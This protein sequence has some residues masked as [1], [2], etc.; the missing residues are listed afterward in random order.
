M[1]YT[2]YHCSNLINNIPN[3]DTS[4]VTNMVC[5]FRD[6]QNLVEVPNFNTNNVIYM[7][8]MFHGCYNLITVPSF[9]ISNVTMMGN[10]FVNCNH[11]SQPS[12]NNIVSMCVHAINVTNK[13]WD[14]ILIIDGTIYN[15]ANY[16]NWIRMAP[17][18]S[19]AVTA[20][21]TNL[22][23]PLVDDPYAGM[24]NSEKAIA[25]VQDYWGGTDG[26]GFSIVNTI[27]DTRYVVAVTDN[28]TTEQFYYTVDT[29]TG[30][31]EE[32]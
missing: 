22:G 20:G 23:D 18:Y 29:E 25:M 19:N 16:S 6:C 14:D 8:S 21:W 30:T 24:T 28:S 10:M 15:S 9:D 17:D 26:Y 11:L 31:V 27:S 1:A 3:F 2:F 12:I 13:N 4:N 5:T 7:N 32:Y